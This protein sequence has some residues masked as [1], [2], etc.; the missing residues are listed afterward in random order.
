M[1]EVKDSLDEYNC[2]LEGKTRKKSQQSLKDLQNNINPYHRHVIGVPECEEIRTELFSNFKFDE[3]HK[4]ED[5]R[6]SKNSKEKT[7][8]KT[9]PK[10]IIKLL[11]TNEKENIL[12]I[13]R[14]E[15]DKL[16]KG[17]NNKNDS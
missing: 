5:A 7:S 13:A 12:K 15:N 8:K 14:G 4:L 17:N 10:H 16:C 2:R 3:N 1:S 9:T 6:S 11:K